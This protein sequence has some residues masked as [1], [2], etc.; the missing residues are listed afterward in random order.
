[1]SSVI[2]DEDWLSRDALLRQDYLSR[3]PGDCGVCLSPAR[4]V[5]DL[6]TAS[7]SIVRFWRMLVEDLTG[8]FGN[9]SY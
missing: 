6:E 5:R 2:V 7:E 4:V 8:K 1:M 3:A 9:P